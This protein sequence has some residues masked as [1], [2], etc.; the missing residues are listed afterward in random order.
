MLQIHFKLEVIKEDNISSG[1]QDK[2]SMLINQYNAHHFWQEDKAEIFSSLTSS[3]LLEH[4]DLPFTIAI[5]RTYGI[6]QS[7]WQQLAT[8]RK[9]ISNLF[10][11]L[12][13]FQLLINICNDECTHMADFTF[14]GFG[15]FQ[16]FFQSFPL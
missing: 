10:L 14:T 11:R 13:L 12:I 6:H 2:A 8:L 5:W 3:L 4:F 9:H 16:S 7:F 15:W 1:L